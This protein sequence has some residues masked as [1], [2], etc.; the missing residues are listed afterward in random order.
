MTTSRSST[1]NEIGLII[2][3]IA[4]CTYTYK[5]QNTISKAKRT[6]WKSAQ[7]HGRNE[8]W[9]IHGSVDVR[10]SGVEGNLEIDVP[11]S[12]IFIIRL[13]LATAIRPHFRGCRATQK[14]HLTSNTQKALKVVI[15]VANFLN[16]VEASDLFFG[17]QKEMIQLR[18]K[19]GVLH[20][21]S[22]TRNPSAYNDGGR[23]R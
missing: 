10:Y 23:G 12:I 9:S 18:C 11:S 13:I 1:G 22:R 8:Y 16:Y 4:M 2:V 7:L 5:I 6:S 19:L 21:C 17:R 15:E 14:K 20:S 3:V